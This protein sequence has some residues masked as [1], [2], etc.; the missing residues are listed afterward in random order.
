MSVS[1]VGI[2]IK[3]EAGTVTDGEARCEHHCTLQRS[4]MGTYQ[5]GV[6]PGERQG[7]KLREAAEEA[8]GRVGWGWGREERGGTAGDR[9]GPRC[10]RPGWPNAYLLEP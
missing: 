3:R 4:W 9:A 2:Q 5:A 10:R 6:P 7:S 1:A 8:V